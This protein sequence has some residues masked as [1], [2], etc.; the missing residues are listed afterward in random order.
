[1]WFLLLI[2][3]IMSYFYVPS[4][5][6]SV[7]KLPS[8]GSVYRSSSPPRQ[9][10]WIGSAITAGASLI[11]GLF[12]NKSQNKNIDKQIAAQKEENQ[13]N[14]EYNLMLAQKQN[15]WNVEQW[16]R[17]NA[18]NDPQAQLDRMRKAGINP[19]LAVGGGYQ[20]TAASSPAM[21]A[22]AASTAQDMSVLGQ[23]P[24]LGQA[25]QS[26]LHDSMLGAQIDN[27]KAN[28]EK[29]RNESSILESDAKFRDAINQGTL[30]MQNSTIQLNNAN[31]KVSDAQISKFRADCRNLDQQTNNLVLEYDKIRATIA[32]LDSNTA[33]ARLH[34]VIDSKKAEAEIK[35]LAAATNLDYAHAKEVTTL[36]SAKLLGL[37]ADSQLKISQSVQCDVTTDKINW[38]LKQAKSFEEVERSTNV[39]TDITDTLFPI[40]ALI[41]T[42]FGGD[43]YESY[44]E[45][46]VDKDGNVSERYGSRK[47]GR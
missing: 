39:I 22:G 13:K 20:N 14:R 19:D 24:T 33:L 41:G 11:G 7:G 1:M 38:D 45:T 28:T 3:Y 36:M 27:I 16:E 40:A 9:N 29:I 31:I 44:H 26:A 37:N 15:A 6:E 17:E 2:A 34:S 8:V 47:K 10:A 35:R 21:T 12:G 23:R 46:T 43:S 42:A 32:N 4:A 25:I 30:D 18:Y 5:S